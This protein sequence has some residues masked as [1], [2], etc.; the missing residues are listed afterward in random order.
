[1]YKE[2]SNNK[3]KKLGKT[4]VKN[5]GKISDGDLKLLQEFRL[6]F[7]PPLGSIFHRLRRVVNKVE[8]DVILAYR[9]KRIDTIINKMFRGTN[10]LSRMGDIAG[11]RCI[12]KTEENV[13]KA[14]NEI[15]T[16]FE[17]TSTTK[18]WIKYSKPIGYKGIHVYVKDATSNKTIE[19]QLRT[20]KHHN[21]A[22]LVEITDILYGTRLKELGYDSDPDFAKFHSLMSSD[23]ELEKEEAEFIYDQLCNTDFISRITNTFRTNNNKVKEQWNKDKQKNSYY[24]LE[25]SKDETPILD[26]YKNFKDAEKAYFNRYN[27]NKKSNI[28]LTFIGNLDFQKLSMAYANYILSYHTFISDIAPI[29]KNMAIEAMEDNRFGKFQ[30]L[31]KTY[32]Q[33]QVNFI[34]DV[35]IEEENL[36][37]NQSNTGVITLTNAKKISKNQELYILEKIKKRLKKGGNE[38]RVF[39][40]ELENV[41]PQSL[42]KGPIFKYFLKRHSNRLRK[43]LKRSKVIFE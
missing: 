8:S 6:T 36:Y 33:L 43:R 13:Y 17:L 26:R 22:T 32:E 39:I 34:I 11:I 21:W 10:D 7:I 30:K 15:I 12:F 19:I 23:K 35:F 40:S 16:K 14:L 38:H 9:I 20:E 27:K 42:L 41:M 37:F 25:A 4:I 3:I 1:M 28:V 18:D 29:I 24:L 5:N 31:F 2:I